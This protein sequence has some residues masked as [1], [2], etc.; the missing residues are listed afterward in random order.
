M[1]IFLS[2][3]DTTFGRRYHTEATE[4]AIVKAS[5]SNYLAKNPD[6][7]VLVQNTSEWPVDVPA[8]AHPFF[9][10][11][12]GH[13]GLYVDVR[14]F[15]SYNRQSGESKITSTADYNLLLARAG[16]EY[17]WRTESPALIRAMSPFPASVFS[18]WLHEGIQTRYGLEPED[19]YKVTI[20]S[21]FFYYSL[22]ETVESPDEQDFLR[23]CKAIATATRI[24]VETVMNVLQGQHYVQNV[25]DY[26]DRLEEITG[27]VRLKGFSTILLYPILTRTWFGANGAEIIACAI[28]HIPSFLSVVLSAIS[29][30]A[31][32]RSSLSKLCERVPAKNSADDFQRQLT[33]MLKSY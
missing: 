27:S 20:F 7:P 3:Y 9:V 12:P 5:V 15:I 13:E 18:S 10:K 4:A 14:P 16:L 25:V 21:A 17:I 6:G 26:C 28:E 32:K 30:R 19:Q 22:F 24:D 2:A 33:A 31:Y 8:F 1:P 29:E 23:V 11:K